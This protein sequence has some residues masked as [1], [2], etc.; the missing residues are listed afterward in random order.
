MAAIIREAVTKY[1]NERRRRDALDWF[2]STY[3]SKCE[4]GCIIGSLEMLKCM[5]KKINEIKK[6]GGNDAYGRKS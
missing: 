3:C 5:M 2:I 6:G 1:L 4:K